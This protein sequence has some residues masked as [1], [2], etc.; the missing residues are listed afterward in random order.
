MKQQFIAWM[1]L[2]LSVLGIPVFF[3]LA[4]WYAFEG[5][6]SFNDA[7]IF[8]HSIILGLQQGASVLDL[9]FEVYCTALL[10]LTPLIATLYLLLPKTAQNPMAMPNGQG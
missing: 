1:S 7:Y 2:L 8:S 6:H 9:K 5:L 4:N 10:A 3:I